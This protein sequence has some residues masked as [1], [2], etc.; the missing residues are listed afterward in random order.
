MVTALWTSDRVSNPSTNSPRMRST[1]QGSVR[2]KA[3]RSCGVAVRKRS[4]S[5]TEVRGEPLERCDMVVLEVVEERRQ[6][7]VPR[8]RVGND[9]RARQMAHGGGR[10]GGGQHHDRRAL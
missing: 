9:A 5:V 6:P 8:P 3:R 1:R 7:Y 2:V 4:S 10:I